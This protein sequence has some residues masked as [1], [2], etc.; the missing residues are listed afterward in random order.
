MC[1]SDRPPCSRPLCRYLYI[2]QTHK[3]A[4]ALYS[5]MQLLG[6]LEG[7]YVLPRGVKQKKHVFDYFL[8]YLRGSE[9]Y[10][11]SI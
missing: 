9:L 2:I 3:L 1:H 6:S 10:I 11:M 8:P 5:E 7:G 4:T